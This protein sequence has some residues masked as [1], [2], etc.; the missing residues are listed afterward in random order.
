MNT[1]RL[2]CI[3]ESLFIIC[4][5][6]SM[7]FAHGTFAISINPNPAVK[8]YSIQVWVDCTITQNYIMSNQHVCL[9]EN[10]DEIER[11]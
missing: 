10:E 6:F 8:T 3:K 9:S 11:Q 5:K 2:R 7:L 4:H 1:L